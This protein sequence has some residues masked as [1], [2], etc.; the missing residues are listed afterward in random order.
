MDN[1]RQV[2]E[3]IVAGLRSATGMSEDECYAAVEPGYVEGSVFPKVIQVCPGPI[4]PGEII[5]GGYAGMTQVMLQSIQ[6]AFLYR[7]H[8]DPHKRSDLQLAEATTGLLDWVEST[9]YD[10]L[11]LTVLG[12]IVLEP[13]YY[14]SETSPTWEDID[15]RVAMV[16]L[17]MTAVWARMLPNEITMGASMCSSSSSSGGP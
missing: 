13:L 12:G 4:T 15:R 3:A 5:E 11:S 6:V 9:Y 17:S 2:L 10:N 7:C 16:V 14:E 8:M 1:A